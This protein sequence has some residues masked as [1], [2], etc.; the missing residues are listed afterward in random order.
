MLIVV[1]VNSGLV[2]PAVLLDVDVVASVDHDVGHVVVAQQ[3]LQRSQSQQLV[4]DLF[5]QARPVAVG[6]QPTVLVKGLADRG[7]DLGRDQRRIEHLHT[8]DVHRLEQPVVD[9]YFKFACGVRAFVPRTPNRATA[10]EG[11][12]LLDR[13]AAVGL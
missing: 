6:Q 9:L 11:A 7:G 8:R 13:G 3:R 2:Q 5:D 1:E 10:K 4:L 12:R